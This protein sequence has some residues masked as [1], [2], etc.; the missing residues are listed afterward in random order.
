[1]AI[2]SVLGIT[3][4]GGLLSANADA[5]LISRLGGTAY[6][7]T[8][9]DITWLTDANYARTS[10]YDSDGLMTWDDSLAWAEQLIV[11]EHDNWR[12]PSY[13]RSADNTIAPCIGYDCADSEMT[14]MYYVNLNGDGTSR[15]SNQADTSPFTNIRAQY[16]SSV[17]VSA[18]HSVNYH[19]NDGLQFTHSNMDLFAAWAVMDG[20]IAEVPA[21]A[22]LWLSLSG[23]SALFVLGK[24]KD[25]FAEARSRV[26]CM[27]RHG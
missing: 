12:L 9:L 24:K 18:S 27:D 5:A 14:F 2:K 21:P 10:G 19:F 26:G 6:Y 3:V 4:L 22:A 13:R 17:T 16:W 15:T 7:D 11:G 1:M 25:G 8:E 23:F 20:D